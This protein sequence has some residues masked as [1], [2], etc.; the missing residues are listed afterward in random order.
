MVAKVTK[1]NIYPED[2]H[3]PS[4][5]ES[6]LVGTTVVLTAGFCL[7]VTAIFVQYLNNLNEH[8]I[9]KTIR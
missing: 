3:G 5:E 4:R 9:F 1:S 8:Q 2:H 7:A 6:C